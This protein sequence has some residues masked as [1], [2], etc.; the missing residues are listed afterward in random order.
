MKQRKEKMSNGLTQKIN[1]QQRNRNK[2][3]QRN[4]L[5]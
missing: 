5:E 4:C 1:G 2:A 3:I